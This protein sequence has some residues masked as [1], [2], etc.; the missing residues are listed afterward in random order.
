MHK[1]VENFNRKMET[2]KAEITR[3]REPHVVIERM[4]SPG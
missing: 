1:Q 4:S 3:N 2:T